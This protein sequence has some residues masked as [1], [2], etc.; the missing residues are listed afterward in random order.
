MANKHIRFPQLFGALLR[1]SP[2]TDMRRYHK[3]GAIRQ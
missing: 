1:I 2:L 3:L